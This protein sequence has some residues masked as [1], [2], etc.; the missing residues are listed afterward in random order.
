VFCIFWVFRLPQTKTK[1][2]TFEIKK[3]L[4]M[5]KVFIRHSNPCFFS[6]FDVIYFIFVW[7]SRFFL[8]ILKKFNGGHVKP[9]F[10]YICLSISRIFF[11]SILQCEKYHRYSLFV[12]F[13]VDRIDGCIFYVNNSHRYTISCCWSYFV[14]LMFCYSLSLNN[15]YIIIINLARKHLIKN[16]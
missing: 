14:Y 8:R 13:G 5:Q 3:N 4:S 9:I 15:V 6:I 10:S 16:T 1:Y 11:F 2:M 12:P 7:S